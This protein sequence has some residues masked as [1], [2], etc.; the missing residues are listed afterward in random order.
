MKSTG[1]HHLAVAF[2]ALAVLLSAG[3]TAANAANKIVHDAEY[4][5]LEA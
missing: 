2:S 1:C 3:A 5:I 4:Y